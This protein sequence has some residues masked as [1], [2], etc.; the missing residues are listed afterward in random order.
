MSI[1]EELKGRFRN[2][3]HKAAINVI[4]T[5]KVMGYNFGQTLRKHEITE[6]QY[7]VLKILR[8]FRSEGPLSINFIKEWMLEKNSDVSR[9]VD[10]LFNLGLVVRK[11]NE[12]DR[13]Q[14]DVDI[15]EKGLQLLGKMDGCELEVDK[16][17]SNLN[18]DEIAELNRL[19][20]KARE[21]EK[22]I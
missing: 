2:D 4:Y 11:E 3:Y 6:Q 1:E 7:N 12:T 21:D 13:R 5:A 16:L 20:D 22:P 8:G 18:H 10:K 14:K 17:F 19:L 15:S 9:L